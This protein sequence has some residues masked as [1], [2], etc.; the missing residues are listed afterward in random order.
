MLH[1]RG[2][3]VTTDRP[4]G[5]V[6]S[7]T[8]RRVGSRG[9]LTAQALQ[10]VWDRLSRTEYRDAMA[11]ADRAAVQ[12]RI[13]PASVRSYVYE[14]VSEGHLEP[15]PQHQYRDVRVTRAGKTFNSARKVRWHRIAPAP[16]AGE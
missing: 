5:I 8:K 16:K 7:T 12:F 11:L 9:G 4:N 13:K 6:P 15:S 2:M 10:W 14:L 1:T 3:K